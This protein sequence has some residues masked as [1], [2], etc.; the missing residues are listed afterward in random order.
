MSDVIINCVQC[1]RDFE[2]SLF[3][4][5]LFSKKGFDEPKRCPECRRN[6]RFEVH[7]SD[8][9]ITPVGRKKRRHQ[10]GKR[11]NSWDSELAYYS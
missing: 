10:R 4:Q 5:N 9:D 2:F 8:S 3:E 6:K 7:E 1:E 11:R